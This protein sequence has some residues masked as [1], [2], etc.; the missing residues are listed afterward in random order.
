[1]VKTAGN[2]KEFP[3]VCLRQILQTK[4]EKRMGIPVSMIVLRFDGISYGVTI[5]TGH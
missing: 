2:K 3:V 5:Q 1:M 4:A